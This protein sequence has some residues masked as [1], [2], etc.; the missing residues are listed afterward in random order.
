M[1]MNQWETCEGSRGGSASSNLAAASATRRGLLV[2]ASL[3]LLGWATRRSALA[4]VAMG[5]RRENQNVFVVVFLRG[6]A[7][8][9]NLLVPH[10]DEAYYRLRPTL[11]VPKGK[12]LDLDGFFGLHPSMTALEPFY[13]SGMLAPIHAVGSDDQTRSHFEAMDTMERGLARRDGPQ[14]GWVARYLA[15]TES[16][17]P[18][19]L[20]AVAL[21]YTTPTSL[22]GASHATTLASLGDYRLDVDPSIRSSLESLY[23]A[24]KDEISH[25]GRETFEVL[26]TLDKLDVKQYKPMDGAK[27]PDSDLGAGLKQVACLIR[28]DVG[29]EVACL[30]KGSWDTHVGQGTE[31]GWMPTQM[32]D[33]SKSL[34]AF[35]T[36]MGPEM[37]RVTVLVMSEF[38][39]RI[40]ENAGLGTDHG[41]GG[42]MFVIGGGVKGG[43]VHAQ[44]Q[45]LDHPVGPGDLGVTTDYRDVLGEILSRRMGVAN[46]ESVFAG[47]RATPLGIV[48]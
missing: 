27:Y 11:S 10:G 1:E 25:A 15:A 13:R 23:G 6:G 46:T 33:L 20:R 24:G 16:A 26:Q 5:S 30:D 36:D 7:D 22:V 17:N 3:G 41:H 21:G 37:R 14:S 34:A 39:R 47:H 19:P 29:M 38:G 12:L 45:G 18:S 8:G 43:K 9:L 28:A 35:A 42:A 4:Q 44:W 40:A 32:D 2:G 48:G 31:A